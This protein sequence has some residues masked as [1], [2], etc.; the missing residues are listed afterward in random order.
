MPKAMKPVLDTNVSAC[1]G[2]DCVEVNVIERLTSWGAGNVLEDPSM[3]SKGIDL[4]SDC[5]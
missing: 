5:L 4:D 3:H 2:S 1:G